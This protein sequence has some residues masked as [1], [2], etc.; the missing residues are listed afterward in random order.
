MNTLP[1]KSRYVVVGGLPTIRPLRNG[2]PGMI[3][4]EYDAVAKTLV[5]NIINNIFKKN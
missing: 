4:S 3:Q 2:K 1:L 5:S